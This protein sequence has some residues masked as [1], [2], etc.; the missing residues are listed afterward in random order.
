MLVSVSGNEVLA[1]IKAGFTPQNIILNGNGKQEYE[2]V[3]MNDFCHKCTYENDVMK[4]L[5]G[6]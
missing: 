5:D 2:N 1:G 3:K 6:K 4:I